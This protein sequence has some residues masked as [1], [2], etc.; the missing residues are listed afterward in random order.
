MNVEIAKQKIQNHNIQKENAKQEALRK[1]E[2]KHQELITEIKKLEQRI[3]EIIEIGNL[4]L[5]NN[6]KI[7]H[8]Y[9]MSHNTAKYK[10]G[11]F[12][13]DGIYHQLGF[14]P[15][16][17]SLQS[18][19]SSHYDFI[20]YMMGG[21]NGNIDFV[22]NGNIIASVPHRDHG[23]EILKY[24]KPTNEH[25]KK[26]LKDFPLFEEKFYEFINKL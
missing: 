11:V 21:A 2:L 6:I 19:K 26:F 9:G 18:N 25:M 8:T 10:Y 15:N 14:Y 24:G 7:W 3:N 23:F 22:T 20:G 12:D 16:N 5:K 4:C 17:H 13:T 1:E